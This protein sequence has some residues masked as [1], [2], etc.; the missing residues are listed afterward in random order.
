MMPESHAAPMQAEVSNA[1]GTVHH[2]ASNTHRSWFS[3]QQS[4]DSFTISPRIVLGSGFTQL[5]H[6]LFTPR[7]ELHI[8]NHNGAMNQ[9]A[10]A[11]TEGVP[12]PRQ[13]P[14]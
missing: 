2:G 4:N 13:A 14:A 5:I 8:C 10:Q 6:T 1:S 9:E 12:S 3:C 7:Y 11:A